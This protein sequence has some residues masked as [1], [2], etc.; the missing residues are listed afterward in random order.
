[1]SF[2]KETTFFQP[3]NGPEDEEKNKDKDKKDDDENK[4]IPVLPPVNSDYPHG[5][6]YD[7]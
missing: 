7:Y 5:G 1:M 3:M 2:S 6:Y 4:P